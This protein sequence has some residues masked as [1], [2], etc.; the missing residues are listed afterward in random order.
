M[1][2]PLFTGAPRDPSHWEAI[3]DINPF[4]VY[5]AAADTHEIIC[6]NRAM[7]QLVQV[8]PGQKCHEAIYQRDEPCNFCKIPDLLAIPEGGEQC[9][10]FDHFNDVDDR[11][12]QMREVL[13]TWVDGRTAKYSIAVDVSELKEA[14]NALAEAHA[15]LELKNRDLNAAIVRAE[16]AALAKN[17]FLATVSHEIRTPMN[18]IVGLS[19]LLRQS[20]LDDT[21]AEHLGTIS[22]AARHLLTLI[23]DI[24]DLS[25]IEAGKLSLCEEE[26]DLAGIMANVRALTVELC[27]GKAVEVV[28]DMDPR[29]DGRYRGDTMRLTQALLNYAGNAAKFT[30]RGRVTLRAKLVEQTAGDAVVRF[31][32]SDTGIGIDE[33]ARARLFA[34]FEQADGSTTRKYGGTG[35]GL[36]ITRSLAQLMKGEV[37]LESEVGSGS[38]FW[39]T[40]RLSH[41]SVPS[42]VLPLA[43]A[44]SLERL[45]AERHGDK[46][47]LLVEDSPINQKV[48]LAF[49]GRAK[50]CV[51][52]AE[53][54]RV[55]VDMVLNRPYDLILMDMQMPEMDGVAATKAIRALPGYAAVPILAMT[56]N[57]F[58]DE[59][60]RCFDAGM[61]DHISKPVTPAILFETLIRWLE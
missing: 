48:A 38:T 17:Q 43:P 61:N 23:N 32:V 21:Q 20:P 46:H 24:L 60:Q 6:T 28:T 29:L 51:D 9:V 12:Y 30:E 39:F 10:V 41:G 44:P 55:A 42:T 13:V 57:I 53:N 26:L 2:P 47:L 19:E 1:I 8:R 56:A 5:V 22:S 50:L 15:E 54:G 40:A 59:R 52:L 45:L 4:P 35:L 14:Q 36:A 3:F 37:G 58:E 49:L 31:E 34:A 33:E 11:W 25:K 27:K 7:R 18:A 16:S